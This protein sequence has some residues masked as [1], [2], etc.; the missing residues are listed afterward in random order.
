MPGSPESSTTWPSP[1]WA[2]AQRS[3]SSPIS[4]SRPTSGREPFLGGGLEPAGRF[5]HPQDAIGMGGPAR[6]PSA[7]ARPGLRSRR[8]RRPT[9]AP[10]RSPRCCRA[11]RCLA[12]GRPDSS[13]R[14]PRLSRPRTRPPPRWRCRCAPAR[15]PASGTS[16]LDKRFDDLQPRMNGALGLAFMRQRIAEE[17]DDAVAQALEHVSFV[18]GN[19]HRAGILVAADDPLQHF[20]IHAVAS[21]VK[22]TM[23]QNSTVSWRRSPV[24]PVVWAAGTLEAPPCVEVGEHLDAGRGEWRRL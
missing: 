7:S 22:P 21:S 5:A 17:G 8:R 19:A 20:G 13:S 11:G 6:C 2:S 16:S 1:S 24:S 14:P 10:A 3:S 9:D 23:S 18:T 12:G 15:C 4:C